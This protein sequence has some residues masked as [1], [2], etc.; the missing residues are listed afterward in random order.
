MS[1]GNEEGGKGWGDDSTSHAPRQPGPQV[2]AH[3]P[4]SANVGKEE[5]VGAAVGLQEAGV[6]REVEVGDVARVLRQHLK[7]R[8]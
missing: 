6:R 7:G 4:A 3:L 1:F 2:R 5:L 8:T